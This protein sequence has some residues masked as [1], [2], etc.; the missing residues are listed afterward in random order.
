VPGRRRSV[1]LR[2]IKGR[3]AETLV[4][5]I[6]RRALYRMTRFGRES[7]PRGILRLGR[8]E[9]FVPDFL[10]LK[11][12]LARRDAPGVYQTFTIEVKYRA[13]LD[14]YLG[15]QQR[16]GE[17]S[18]LAKSKSKWP[19]LYV[20]FVTDRPGE[21]RSCFQALDARSYAPG[22]PVK[23]QPL[24]EIAALEIY[25]NNVIEHEELARQLFGLLSSLSR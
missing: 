1:D 9:D 13:D 5:S 21:G 8:D 19:N 24:Y 22:E 20:V 18:P 11:G 16:G 6:F 15:L 25:P 23:T 12:D 4:E 14:R 3:L 10:A 17:N 2:S 7:D